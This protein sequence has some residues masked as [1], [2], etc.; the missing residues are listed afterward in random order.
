M[1][2][3][4]YKSLSCRRYWKVLVARSKD[5]TYSSARFEQLF[6]EEVATQLNITSLVNDLNPSQTPFFAKCIQKIREG[7]GKRISLHDPIE[8]TGKCGWN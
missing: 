7:D 3:W 2:V 6:P 4:I 1:S 5:N 8:N